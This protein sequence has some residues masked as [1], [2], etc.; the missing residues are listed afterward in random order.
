MP[1]VFLS[2]DSGAEPPAADPP[3]QMYTMAEAARPKGVSYHTVSGAVRRDKLPA[4]RL[5]R[6]ALISAEDLRAWRPMRERA[7]LKYRRREPNLDATP[8]LLDLASGER[9]DLARRLG[10]LYEAIHAA[11]LALPTAEFLA[12]LCERLGEALG[13]RRVALWGI[14]AAG[15]RA[16]RLA[17]V[18]PPL[19]D[20]PAEV[21]LGRAPAFEAFVEAGE[22]TAREAA[23]F[24]APPGTLAGVTT[25]F[26][27][28][29]RVEGR[30][31][32]VVIGDRGGAPFALSGDQLDLARGVANHA[33]VALE[34]ARLR[35]EAAALR[36]EVA[37][38]RAAGT[39][40]TGAAPPP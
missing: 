33:A 32:G 16:V 3:D 10:V 38:L 17:A 6:M 21:P 13:L 1:N 40:A 12:L 30:P 37:A 34:L 19:S 18:G 29:L 4:Q 26:A 15:R 8:A 7:P 5:G 22:A 9:V 25:L 27:A 2:A 24:G 14:D 39:A 11:A 28:P 31:L 36:A 23:A 35:D 20:L